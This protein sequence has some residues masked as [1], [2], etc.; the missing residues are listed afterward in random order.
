MDRTPSAQ[1]VS[2]QN[3]MGSPKYD[4]IVEEV[5]QT[6]TPEGTSAPS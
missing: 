5:K 1:H 2:V 3:F 6:N 4:A